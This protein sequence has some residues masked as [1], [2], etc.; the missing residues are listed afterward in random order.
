MW[1]LLDRSSQLKVQFACAIAS[2]WPTKRKK[3]SI[4]S[5][6]IGVAITISEFL[7]LSTIKTMAHEDK[8]IIWV[9]ID[10]WIEK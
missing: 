5:N 8:E 9:Y 1:Q 7:N 6:F 4:G 2:S 10:V 3:K